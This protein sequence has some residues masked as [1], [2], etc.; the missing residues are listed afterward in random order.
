MVDQK[1]CIGCGTC[2]DICPVG[3]IFFNEDQKAEI[4]PKKCIKCGTC[5]AVCPVN[6]IQIKR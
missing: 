3:A 5:E 6:A 2:V 4:D 1:K